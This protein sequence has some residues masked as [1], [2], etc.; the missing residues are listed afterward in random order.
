DFLQGGEASNQITA[1]PG[2]DRVRLRGRGTN[3]ISTGSGA[4][5]VEAYAAGSTR[6][7]CGPGVDTVRIGFN[8]RVR[9]VGCERVT[10]RYRGA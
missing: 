5:L 8:R 1:G 10:R 7:D 2:N 3:R 9:T 6:V 4:D